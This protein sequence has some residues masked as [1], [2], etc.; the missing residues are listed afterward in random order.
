MIGQIIKLQLEIANFLSL[1]RSSALLRTKKTN[2]NYIEIFTKEASSVVIQWFR[3]M[4]KSVA[5]NFP[6]VNFSR[7]Q[8]FVVS[9]I[10]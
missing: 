2:T 9:D 4:V 3:T 8:I 10:T 5:L 6:S 1:L 7:F